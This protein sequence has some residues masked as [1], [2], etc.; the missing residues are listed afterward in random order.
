MPSLGVILDYITTALVHWHSP[1]PAPYS[2]SDV[3]RLG[4]CPTSPGEPRRAALVRPATL[5]C[6]AP[7]SPRLRVI[8]RVCTAYPPQVGCLAACP[9]SGM[10]LAVQDACQPRTGLGKR[11]RG[12]CIRSDA[13]PD[14]TFVPCYII[15]VAETQQLWRRRNTGVPPCP[16][17]L[18]ALAASRPDLGQN[19]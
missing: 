15:L 4:P 1:G 19:C 3:P 16:V 12:N 13:A 6:P 7:C 10:I 9:D 17:I 14:A 18:F 8:H 5:A 2:R 11:W